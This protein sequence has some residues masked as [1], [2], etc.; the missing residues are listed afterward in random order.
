MYSM[1]TIANTAV[2][3]KK[4]VKKVN[5]KGCHQKEC[6]S[7]YEK[8]DVSCTYCGNHFKIYTIQAIML[9]TLAAYLLSYVGGTV[10]NEIRKET[11]KQ[12]II[13]ETKD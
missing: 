13:K 1:M 12:P 4:V 7:L 2:V 10:E 11:G 5:P 3:Y 6:F 8:M 9:Y